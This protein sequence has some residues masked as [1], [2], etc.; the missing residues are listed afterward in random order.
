MAHGTVEFFGTEGV[1][2]P[3]IDPSW[4]FQDGGAVSHARTRASEL[5]SSGDEIK[6]AMHGDK[7]TT[8]FTYVFR[9]P[10]PAVQHYVWP[11]VGAV[12]G[13]WH[14]DSFSCA[15]SRD[16]ASAVLT[17]NCHRH[18]GA[19][20]DA[21]RTYT[22]SL[23]AVAPVPFGVPSAFGDAFALDAEAAVD[24]RSATYSVQAQHVDEAA[25]DGTHLRG[26]NHD[27]SETLAVELTGA[28]TADDYA[29]SW[30]MPAD[31]VTPSNAGATATS[32]TFEH[33]LAHDVPAEAGA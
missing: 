20:H 29:T 25:R 7:S 31:T 12:A 8:S 5:G 1:S 26:D 22:P 28:A 11:K 14:V 23:A 10:Q 13:G 16:R 30:D 18:D 27:G 19:A 24:L 3:D 4:V 6:S 17:L 2:A 9:Q 21:G 32:L 15:W 33:H